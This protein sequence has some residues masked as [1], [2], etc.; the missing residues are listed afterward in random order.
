MDDYDLFYERIP[1][2]QEARMFISL[3]KKAWKTDNSV[4]LKESIIEMY[5]LLQRTQDRRETLEF[6]GIN[7]DT[8]GNRDIKL[9]LE[10]GELF[11]LQ[12]KAHKLF[13]SQMDDKFNYI[14]ESL[15]GIVITWTR[16]LQ[17]YFLREFGINRLEI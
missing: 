2:T 17:L 13:G 1:N 11:R 8:L 10:R 14:R 6:S 12:K 9:C 4:I 5:N 15:Y 7:L 3:L 16:E